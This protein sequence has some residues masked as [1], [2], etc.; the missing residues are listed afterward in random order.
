MNRVLNIGFKY[1]GNWELQDNQ[2]ECNFKSH[3]SDKNVLYAFVSNG[4][5]KYIGKTTQKLSS[6]FSGYRNPSR[7][8]STNIKNN[9][10]IKRFLINKEPID[11]FVLPDNGLLNYGGFSINLAAGL[12]DSLIEHLSPPWNDSGVKQKQ[13]QKQKQKTES[14]VASQT[15]TIT[16]IKLSNNDVPAFELKLG[17]AYYNQGFFNV[18]IALSNNFASH[19]EEIEIYTG[20]NEE[21]IIG[22]IN[23]TANTN[24]TPRIMGGKDLRNW[25]M[26]NFK[27]GEHFKVNINTTNSVTLLPVR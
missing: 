17:K 22:Y 12:E 23:R 9:A 4:E 13:K 10:N 24:S 14:E 1:A 20:A 26:S 8:Q 2:I 7:T 6:R 15:N 11:V 19:S 21:P 16:S 18:P 27:L 25:I 3:S 5:V